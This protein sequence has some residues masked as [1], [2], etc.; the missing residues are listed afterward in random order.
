MIY[1]KFLNSKVLHNTPSNNNPNNNKM[2]NNNLHKMV[3]W[4]IQIKILKKKQII[5]QK[6]LMIY[7]IFQ[8]IKK[9]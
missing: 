3:K 9:N 7:L 4:E 5:Q 1:W 6:K 8:E 2:N